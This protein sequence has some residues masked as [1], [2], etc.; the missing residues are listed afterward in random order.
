[1]GAVPLRDRHDRFVGSRGSRDRPAG[2]VLHSLPVEIALI[3]VERVDRGARWHGE[4][5]LP[6]ID[7]RDYEEAA[8]VERTLPGGDA[9]VGRV[10]AARRTR[11]AGR[12]GRVVRV[13][14]DVQAYF[15]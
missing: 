14:A 11:G 10:G 5:F 9:L 1:M 8:P 2:D 13:E 4:L 7:D 6:G 15:A 12:T 3:R